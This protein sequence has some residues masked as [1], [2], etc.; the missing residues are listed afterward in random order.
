[1]ISHCS[2][3]VLDLSILESISAGERDMKQFVREQGVE[4]VVFERESG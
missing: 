4:M 1:M 3:T 2:L